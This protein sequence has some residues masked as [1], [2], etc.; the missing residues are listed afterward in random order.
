[1][2]QIQAS[3]NNLV[4]WSSGLAGSLGSSE[5]QAVPE[6]PLVLHLSTTAIH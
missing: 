6:L 2:L 5:A 3:V 1:M 4:G